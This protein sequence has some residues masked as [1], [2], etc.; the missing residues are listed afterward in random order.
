MRDVFTLMST[1]HGVTVEEDKFLRWRITT[2]TVYNSSKRVQNTQTDVE[3]FRNGSV[4]EPFDRSLYERTFMTGPAFIEKHALSTR[5]SYLILI[6]R[7]IRQILSCLY[8]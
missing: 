1:Y 2:D 8:T 4:I 3:R 7:N 6:R 5:L